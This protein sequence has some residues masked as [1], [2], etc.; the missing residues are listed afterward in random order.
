MKILRLILAIVVIALAGYGLVTGNVGIILPYMLLV[1][2]LM[3]IVMGIMEFQKRK[4]DA[5]NL[6][7]VSAFVLFVG[8]YTL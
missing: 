3:L 1:T 2:S 5:F 8:I 7:L 6:F 4:A